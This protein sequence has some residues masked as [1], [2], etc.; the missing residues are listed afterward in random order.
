[1]ATGLPIVAHD[2]EVTRWIVGDNAT[3]V[4]STQPS[5]LVKGLH[6][7]LDEANQQ[8]TV[9]DKLDFVN[10]RF[11]WSSISHE[12][13]KFIKQVLATQKAQASAAM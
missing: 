8:A 10:R 11:S 13:Y 7:A 3:L 4:D 9:S 6:Q 1:M 2:R 5:E 12:Y